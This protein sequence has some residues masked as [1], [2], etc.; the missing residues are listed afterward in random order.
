MIQGND[1]VECFT[2]MSSILTFPTGGRWGLDATIP[3]DIL[4]MGSTLKNWWLYYFVHITVD[5]KHHKNDRQ[6]K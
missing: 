3:H 5:F 4:H 2:E 6:N 1:C